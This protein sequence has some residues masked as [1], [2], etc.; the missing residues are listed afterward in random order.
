[1]EGSGPT[2]AGAAPGGET[3]EQ[4]I[5]RLQRENDTLRQA[6]VSE[7][8]PAATST[9]HI[10]GGEPVHPL[11]ALKASV[12]A[13]PDETFAQHITHLADA[14][15]KVQLDPGSESVAL[16]VLAALVGDLIKGVKL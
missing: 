4:T 2:S 15:V 7:D 11:D 8:T 5:E 12:E 6:E 3:P 9:T 10:G 13:H 14:G 16:G 1:M